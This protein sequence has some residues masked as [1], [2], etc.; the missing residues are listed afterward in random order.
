MASNLQDILDELE[1]VS[2]GSELTLGEALKHFEGRSLGVLLVI[3]AA[4]TIIPVIGAL[5]GLPAVA[6]FVIIALAGQSLFSGKTAIWLPDRI[7]SLSA[8]KEKVSSAVDKVKPW[9][10]R[11]DALIGP[12]MEF[13]VNRHVIALSAMVLAFMFIPLGFIP[14]AVSVPAMAIVF[15][16]LALL[17]KDGGAAAIGYAF[18]A[19][20]LW[21]LWDLAPRATSAVAG[22]FS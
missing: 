12:R 5:P 21:M 8:E 18:A 13:L 22:V 4:L 3:V 15:L 1:N 16:G 10:G 19:V 7:S 9:A 2:E 20:S 14:W 17:G 11:I 6:A